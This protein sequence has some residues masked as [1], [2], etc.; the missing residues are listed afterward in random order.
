MSWELHVDFDLD[1]VRDGTELLA[2]SIATAGKALYSLE[3]RE[4]GSGWDYRSPVLVKHVLDLKQ[5][6]ATFLC[7]RVQRLDGSDH[8]IQ[9]ELCIQI[10]GTKLHLRPVY[11]YLFGTKHTGLSQYRRRA[12]AM[13]DFGNRQ[14]WKGDEKLITGEPACED[15]LCHWLTIICDAARPKSLYVVPEEDVSVPLNY[16]M[17][18]HSCSQGHVDDLRDLAQLALKGGYDYRDGRRKYE[19]L[20]ASTGE[21]MLFC[22]RAGGRLDDL[23]NELR[24]RRPILEK[25]L[26]GL[27]VPDEIVETA[28]LGSTRIE[29]MDTKTGLGI[30]AEPFLRYY[31]ENFYLHMLHLLATQ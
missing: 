14:R 26:D 16:H 20:L 13:L 15:L 24:E 7:E 31:S 21:S 18:Y 9:L 30:I 12:D 3:Y 8:Y 25:L 28:A 27:E 22:R 29:P 2:A 1:D 23:K 17:V 19:A 4:F 10:Q 11:L 6:H 5:D